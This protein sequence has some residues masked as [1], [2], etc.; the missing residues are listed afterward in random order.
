MKWITTLSF[1]MIPSPV[2]LLLTLLLWPGGPA[3]AQRPSFTDAWRWVQFSTDDGLPANRVFDIVE[4][5]DGTIWAS[6]QLGVACFNGYYWRA[7]DTTRGLRPVK[8]Q[9]IVAGPES[10]L[11]VLSGGILYQGNARGFHPAD[12]HFPKSPALLTAI[13]PLGQR[14]YL[15]V[16][17]STLYILHGNDVQPYQPALKF[18]KNRILRVWATNDGTVW[19]NTLRGLYR[20]S[21]GNFVQVMAAGPKPIGVVAIVGGMAGSPIAF[22]NFPFES[23]GVWELGSQRPPRH[24]FTNAAEYIH[25]LSVM[26]NGNALLMVETGGAKFRW[27]GTWS[28]EYALPPQMNDVVFV[29]F[30]SNEDLWVGSETGLYLYRGSSRRWWYWNGTGSLGTHSTNE[31]LQAHDGSVWLA[32]GFGLE[33]R[34]GDTL[35]RE[36][37]S[38]NGVRLNAVTGL[39]E[40][41]AG[42]IWIS[43]GSGFSG[44]FRW[45]GVRWKHFGAREG[46]PAAQ[47]HRIVRDDRGHLW[48]LAISAPEPA[49][50]DPLRQPGAF[51]YYDGE[52]TLWSRKDGLPGGNVYSFARGAKGELWFGTD[53]G[54][55]RWHN[56]EWTYWTIA[57]GLYSNRVFTMTV[58]LKNRLWFSDQTNGVAYIENDIPHYFSVADGLISDAV[59]GLHTD[60][61]GHVWVATRGGLSRYDDGAWA[62]FGVSSGLSRARLWPVLTIGDRVY[63][64]TT[65]GGTAILH[66]EDQGK[67]DPIILMSQPV[68]EKGNV[69]FRWKPYGYFGEVSPRDLHTRYRLD[70][71]AWSQWSAS[72]E[73]ALGDCSPG[74]H[75]FTVQARS[76]WGTFETAGETVEFSVPYP[77]Y[78]EPLFLVPVGGLALTTIAVAG[79][80]AFRKQKLTVALAR[81]EARYRSVVE[82]QSEF[83]MRFLPDGTRTFV[84]RAYSEYVGKPADKLVGENFFDA[85]TPANIERVNRKLGMLSPQRPVVTDEHLSPGPS[86]EARWHQWTDRAI[87]D[88]SGF[89]VEYQAVGR[90]TTDRRKAEERIRTSLL[91][92]DVLLK[93]VHHR[94]KNNLQVVSSLLS[95][96]S[97]YIKD[98]HSLAL[99]QES[100]NR[101]R[102][103]ALI[104]EKLYQSKDLADIDF[105]AYVNNLTAFLYRSYVIDPSLVRMEVDV[106][107]ASVNIDKAIPCGLIINELV[108]NSLKY[109]F[110]GGRGGRVR[111]SLHEQ[112]DN[113]LHLT[114]G[115]DGVGVPADF[116][117]RAR[118]SLGMQLVVSL[119]AQLGAK[120]SMDRSGGTEFHFA[121]SGS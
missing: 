79:Y 61:L 101:V 112:E 44:A 58:D 77:L 47:V 109:A 64:G 2:Y 21:N 12:I 46:L 55:G 17:D 78:R 10:T 7:M 15:F 73:L 49:Y 110:P 96:Q 51:E 11:Y 35:V 103:M 90:D 104:H 89:V 70:G 87:F 84:N 94:V 68:V 29:K 45:D 98:Q 27:N 40:D 28:E 102:T 3:L 63:V 118:S 99:F 69:L 43:S 20:E 65:G 93:E 76:F 116:D 39:A 25:S 121:F 74:D 33:V 66:L 62:S 9:T 115:D 80:S 81:S 95:L 113:V 67:H 24:I 88:E 92:K 100:Q 82:D 52:F 120:W 54:L 83:I 8:P 114:V 48:F 37:E 119:A 91:E 56:G 75:R 34:R 31:I 53:Q 71:G 117:E 1:R 23:K 60:S 85:L 57:N 42:H 59:W 19:V 13:V 50:V 18:E 38:A 97:N 107:A 4:T 111:V 30:R 6:T 41:A 106:K 108:S 14:G 86:G 26:D 105:A 5:A 16:S 32:R 22:I 72:R 36:F